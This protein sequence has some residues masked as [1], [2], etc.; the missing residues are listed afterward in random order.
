MSDADDGMRP[1]PIAGGPAPKKKA[2]YPR[3]A[4]L[5]ASRGTPAC[6]SVAAIGQDGAVHAFV[7]ELLEQGNVWPQVCF[8]DPDAP[9]C[10]D[11]HIEAEDALAGVVAGQPFRCEQCDL[12]QT[13]DDRRG[14]GSANVRASNRG[15]EREH[16]AAAALYVG[17][18]VAFARHYPRLSAFSPHHDSDVKQR[19][20]DAS[21][22]YALLHEIARFDFAAKCLYAA[23]L[24]CFVLRLAPR[25]TR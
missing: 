19:A 13:G 25:W 10:V 12:L 6:S 7:G 21:E 20:V 16:F 9:V 3:E 17:D 15:G 11:A 1:F 4:A 18:D 8:D 23:F 5:P 14:R 2:G 22:R 24:P